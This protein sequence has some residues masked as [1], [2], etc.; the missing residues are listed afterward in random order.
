M[1]ESIFALLSASPVVSIVLG[2]LLA[3]FLAFLFRDLI[4]DLI[5][6]YIKKKYNLYDEAEIKLALEK[7]TQDNDLYLKASEKL[8]PSIEARIMK[9]LKNDA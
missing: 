1:I 9:H 8:T 7:S 4:T 5:R 6:D 3:G 2:F